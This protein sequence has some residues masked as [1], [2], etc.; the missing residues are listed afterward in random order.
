MPTKACDDLANAARYPW[1]NWSGQKVDDQWEISSCSGAHTDL[2]FTEA[3]A[4]H[5]IGSP[6]DD[7]IQAW[8]F[9]QP[10]S[11]DQAIMYRL[12]LVQGIVGRL[13]LMFGTPEKMRAWIDPVK[14]EQ[15][16]SLPG[17]IAIHDDLR[18]A[19]ETGIAQRGSSPPV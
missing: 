4:L 2:G 11:I 18:N 14:H 5:I 7:V 8:Q 1:I 15:F 10:I 6:N 19:V 12:A 13:Y 16:L 17:L 9:Q 3:E